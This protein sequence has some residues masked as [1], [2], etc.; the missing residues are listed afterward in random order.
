M[1]KKI[2]A[3]DK[4]RGRVNKFRLLLQILITILTLIFILNVHKPTVSYCLTWYL[5]F[6]YLTAFFIILTAIVVSSQPL[7]ASIPLVII[8]VV[9]LIYVYL[10][11][12]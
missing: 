2:E 1:D 10:G 9:L 8:L 3:K 7:I 11:C 4:K 5:E 12:I 6:Y